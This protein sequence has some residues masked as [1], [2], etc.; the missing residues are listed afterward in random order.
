TVFSSLQDSHLMMDE[1]E[2]LHRRLPVIATLMKIEANRE[3]E[4][5]SNF[6]VAAQDLL[7]LNEELKTV[8]TSIHTNTTWA[9]EQFKNIYVREAA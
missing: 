9:L 3:D 8:I 5:R 1:M 4:F 7:E 2:Q 6:T